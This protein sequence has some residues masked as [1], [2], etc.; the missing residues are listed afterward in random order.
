MSA[1]PMPF[2]PGQP[3][4]QFDY[5]SLS[6][7]GGPL[8]SGNYSQPGPGYSGMD[9]SGS[10]MDTFTKPGGTGVPNIGAATPTGLP[11][12]DMSGGGPMSWLFGKGTKDSPGNLGTLMGAAGSLASGFM[13]MKQY[14][15]AKDTLAQNKSQ[16]EQN[17]SAQKGLTNASLEDRQRARVASNSGAYQS[18][19]DYMSKNGVK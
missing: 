16:F 1:M 8:G 19:G 13:A 7:Y 12:N 17:F 6:G 4:N 10:W 15:L 14:G 11:G 3:G 18:V 2:V 9:G 5:S